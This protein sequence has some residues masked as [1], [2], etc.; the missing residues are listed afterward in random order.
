MP[1]SLSKHLDSI[2]GDGNGTPPS[3]RI[4]IPA[5]MLLIAFLGLI[6]PVAIF[7]RNLDREYIMSRIEDARGQAVAAKAEAASLRAEET[8]RGKT[9]AAQLAERDKVISGQLEE[10]KIQLH[11]MDVS[12]AEHR[13]AEAARNH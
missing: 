11:A 6:W 5:A 12:L 9:V 2:P 10:I 1:N 13:A 7:V 4:S 8:E 3:I